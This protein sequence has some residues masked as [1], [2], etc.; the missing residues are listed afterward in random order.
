MLPYRGR[1]DTNLVLC[2]TLE[3]PGAPQPQQQPQQQQQQQQQQV[4]P[5]LPPPPE[6]EAVASSPSLLKALEAVVAA[7]R[8]GL[9]G[10]AAA[11]AA[12]T[13]PLLQAGGAK[14]P[15]APNLIHPVPATEKKKKKKKKK[16]SLPNKGRPALITVVPLAEGAGKLQCGLKEVWICGNSVILASQK[17]L[18]SQTQGL[19]LG[20]KPTKAY[21]YWRGVQGMKWEQLLPLLHEI[22]HLRFSPSLII[23][24]VGEDD[25][26]PGNST[27]FLMAM[28]NDLGVLRRAFINTFIIWSSLLPKQVWGENQKPEEMEK[29]RKDINSKMIS[30]CKQVGVQ[31][32]PHTSITSDKTGLFLPSLND[33]SDAGADH[34]I[35]D[36]KGV[37]RINRFYE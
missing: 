29:L 17:R 10:P 32:M 36:L 26:L 12:A 4:P 9:L 5:H 30:R 21:V 23:I 7:G 33:L 11:A 37:L 20:I 14:P 24:H 3:S 1:N 15:A 8:R 25:L 35:A 34:F 27:S 28:K 31:F 18:Q 6:K 13:I 19:Q 16:K 2:Q 22:Y